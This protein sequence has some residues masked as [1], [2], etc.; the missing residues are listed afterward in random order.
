MSGRGRVWLVNWCFKPSQ[1]LGIISR[2]KKISVKRCIVERTSKAKTKPEEERRVCGMK[3]S[4]KGHKDRNK[5][6]NRMGTKR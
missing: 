6:K 3:Y 1:P 4:R 5:H 2:L